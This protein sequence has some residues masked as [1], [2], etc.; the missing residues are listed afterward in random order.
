GGIEF[1]VG[2]AVWASCTTF[3]AAGVSF[4][5][6]GVTF[7]AAGA[8]AREWLAGSEVFRA[9]FARFETAWF[10][11]SAEGFAGEAATGRTAVAGVAIGTRGEVAA[12][13]AGVAVAAEGGFTGEAL[14][15]ASE[16]AGP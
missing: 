9:A 11:R 14:E 16:G 5:A 8:V 12:R 10:A 15:L 1:A 6:A 3:F 13:R 4:A 7:V 2:W